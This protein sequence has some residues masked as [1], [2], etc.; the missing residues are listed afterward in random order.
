[1]FE[2]RRDIGKTVYL[3]REGAEKV[4]EEAE[5]ALKEMEGK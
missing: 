1:M 3:T 2:T 4:I 5:K